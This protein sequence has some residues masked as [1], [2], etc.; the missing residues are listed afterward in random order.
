MLNILFLFK[1]VH[2]SDSYGGNIRAKDFGKN[3]G[4]GGGGGGE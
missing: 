1:P 4:G 2:H 3:T